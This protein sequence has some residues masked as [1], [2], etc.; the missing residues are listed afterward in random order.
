VAAQETDMTRTSLSV[1][2]ALVVGLAVGVVLDRPRPTAEVDPGRLF[3]AFTPAR[4]AAIDLGSVRLERAGRQLVLAGGLPTDEAAVRDVVETLEYLAVRRELPADPGRAAARGLDPPLLA[5]TVTYDD[6][7]QD[8]VHL[9]AEEPTL[10]RAWAATPDGKRVFLVEGY[11]RRAL[12]RTPDDLRRRTLLVPPEEVTRVLLGDTQLFPCVGPD[13]LRPDRGQIEALVAQ[14]AGLRVTHFAAWNEPAVLTVTVGDTRVELGGPCPGT[15]DERLARAPGVSGCVPAE[16]VVALERRD[17][18]SWVDLSLAAGAMKADLIKTAEFTLTRER[19]I[20]RGL[21]DL[22][23]D[24]VRVWLEELSAARAT[25]FHRAPPVAAPPPGALTIGDE[26]LWLE[27]DV[28]RRAGEPIALEVSPAVRVLLGRTALELADRTLASFEPWALSRIETDEEVV[29]RQGTLDSWR[30]ERPAD[31]PA[32]GDAV[33]ALRDAA[34]ALRAERVVAAQATPAHQLERKLTLHIDAPPGGAPA[35]ITLLLDADGCLARV[36]ARSFVFE[37]PPA[38][39]AALSARLA[40]REVLAVSLDDATEISV[41]DERFE[42]LGP[43]WTGPGG[44]ALSRER[45]SWLRELVGALGHAEEVVGYGEGK[46]GTP[47]AITTPAGRTLV[48][49]D[50][51]I[52]W[53]EGRPVR[54]RVR[55]VL[56]R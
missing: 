50:G 35:Q 43:T 33:A 1:L 21:P 54:Y 2:S 55:Q 31:L 39:C 18:R 42:R 20:W 32:D 49:L 12:L 53:V 52:A 48:R 17:P 13:C 26:T 47:I 46:G 9:G 34:S 16:P 45:L 44:T 56:P 28:V 7:T 38:A 5:V 36:P 40:S 24:S 41:G 27:G 22:D 4:V 15:P 10:G 29:V 30:L 6:G 19:G 8:R 23:E 14:L 11:A 25:G 3:P 51:D 37:L